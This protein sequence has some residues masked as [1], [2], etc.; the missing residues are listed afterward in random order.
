VSASFD[1][2]IKLWNGVKGTFVAT[3]TGHVGAV[4]QIAWSADSRLVVSGSKDSTL[5]VWACPVLALL[6]SA[7]SPVSLGLRR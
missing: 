4:Y 1:K 7:A 6:G 5:K 3:F 2:S